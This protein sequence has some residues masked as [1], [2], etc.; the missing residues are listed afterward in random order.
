MKFI[1][2]WDVILNGN[3]AVDVFDGM[4]L[5]GSGELG[6]GLG[7]EEWGSGERDVLQNFVSRTDGLIDLI[8]SRFGDAPGEH[9]GQKKGVAQN[10][11]W[12]G[13]EFCPKP[14]DGVIF[15]G[16]GAVSRLSVTQV[17]QWME[18]I[19]RYG[20][21]AY[22]V[23]DDPRSPRIRRRRKVRRGDRRQYQKLDLP[24]GIPP[25]L[26]GPSLPAHEATSGRR[27]SN[28]TGTSNLTSVGTEAFMKVLTLGYGSAWG[29]SVKDKPSAEP[30]KADFRGQDAVPSPAE[31]PGH[32][33]LGLRDDLENED[34]DEDSKNQPNE[35]QIARS[36]FVLRRLCV[37][38][39]RELGT[40]QCCESDDGMDYIDLQAVIYVVSTSH[41]L[42]LLY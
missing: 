21:D 38:G 37:E 13:C 16:T 26:I 34:S 5:S 18:W 17:S 24:P 30:L 31:A 12:L 39:K 33:I 28:L 7:E 9:Q 40:S 27:F 1:R 6:I 36:K 25:P 22:G 32:F 14:S 19:F 10:D 41:D 3:P 8:V 35:H 20:E 15:S 42:T 11:A 23:K 4:K 29:G 2:R